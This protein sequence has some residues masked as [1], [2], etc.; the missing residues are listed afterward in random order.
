MQEK[1]RRVAKDLSRYFV[2]LMVSAPELLRRPVGETKTMFN[3]VVNEDG[4]RIGGGGLHAAMASEQTT[5]MG[6]TLLYAA[7]YGDV[8]VHRQR[9]SQG[10]EFI[11]HLW[12]LLYHLGNDSWEHK[13]DTK[14]QQQQQQQQTTPTRR[15]KTTTKK[16]M[17]RKKKKKN[18]KPSV[19]REAVEQAAAGFTFT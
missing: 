2:Y 3:A 6:E 11:T 17:R 15:R 9:L 13:K 12:A 18:R 4:L 8:E 19:K 10:G 1:N 16:K 14:Q 5:I 7:P